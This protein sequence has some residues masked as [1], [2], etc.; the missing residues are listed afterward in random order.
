MNCPIEKI[1]DQLRLFYT[2]APKEGNDWKIVLQDVY[3]FKDPKHLFG[4]FLIQTNVLCTKKT[5]C[6]GLNR[7]DCAVWKCKIISIIK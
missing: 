4:N 6:F 5:D 1:N 7:I 3:D 2:R